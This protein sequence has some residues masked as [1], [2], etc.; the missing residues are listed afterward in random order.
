[1]S[2]DMTSTR[3]LVLVSVLAFAMTAGLQDAA[4][5]RRATE[6]VL[7]GMESSALIIVDVQVRWGLQQSGQ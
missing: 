1:M 7:Q 2:F 6:G 5:S 3:R 4:E